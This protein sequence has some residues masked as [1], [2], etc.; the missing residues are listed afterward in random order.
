MITRR[1]QRQVRPVDCVA[2]RHEDEPI[3]KNGLAI[4]PSEMMEMMQQGQPISAQGYSIKEETRA[5][6]NDYD[7]PLEHTRHFDMVDAWNTRMMVQQKV[8]DARKKVLS[9]EIPQMA[10]ES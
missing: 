6:A 1:L 10:A 7:V 2:L 4:T 9:G 8:R 3:V 5:M